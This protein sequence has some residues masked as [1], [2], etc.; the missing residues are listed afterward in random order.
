[1]GELTDI[2][3]A[4]LD[5]ENR[6]WWKYAGAKEGA[7]F[8]ELGMSSTRYYQRLNVLIEKPEAL[9]YQPMLVRRLQR[10]RA[11]R[12]QRRSTHRLSTSP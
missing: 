4:I 7:I 6:G 2:E 1:M 3:K 10:Q 9:A 12:R 5:F 11:A 8:V